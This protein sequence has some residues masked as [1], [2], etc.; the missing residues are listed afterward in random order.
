VSAATFVVSTAGVAVVS[1]TFV[2]STAVV[3]LSQAGVASVDPFPPHDV[4]DTTANR[5]SATNVTFFILF[6]FCLRIN[7]TFDKYVVLSFIF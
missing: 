4:N 2:V 7:F 3:Q 5:L 6:V 1:T